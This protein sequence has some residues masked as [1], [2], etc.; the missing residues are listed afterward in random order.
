MPRRISK[1]SRLMEELAEQ[2]DEVKAVLKSHDF[3][4]EECEVDEQECHE[5]FGEDLFRVYQLLN[6]L[7]EIA[8]EH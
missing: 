5:E 2:L 7:S 3:D 8:Q 6:E 1:N 4:I